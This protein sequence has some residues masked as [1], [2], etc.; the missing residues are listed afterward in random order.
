MSNDMSPF[1]EEELDDTPENII[2]IIE[3]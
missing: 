3:I 2:P 1:L